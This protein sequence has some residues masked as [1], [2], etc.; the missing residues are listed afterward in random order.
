MSKKFLEIHL[1]QWFP[2]SCINRDDSG[3]PKSMPLGGE[4]RARWSSQSQ[5]Y[6]LRKA[7]ANSLETETLCMKTRRLPI[8]ALEVLKN[9]DRDGSEAASRIV[10]AMMTLGLSLN[11]SLASKSGESEEIKSDEPEEDVPDFG[12]YF[13]GRTQ[14]ILPV[15]QNADVLLADAVEKH[16][17]VLG[18]EVDLS[19]KPKDKAKASASLKKAAFDDLKKVLDVQRLVDVALFG[20]FLAEVPDGNVDGTC[21]VSH[22]F[23]TH[24]DDYVS[25]FWSAVDDDQSNQGHGGSAN[26]GIQGLTGGC[27]YRYG[28]IDLDAFGSDLLSEDPALVREGAA[29]F[30]REFT[31]LRPRAMVHGTAPYIDPALVVVTVSDTPRMLG[32]AFV[33]PVEEDYLAESA[34]RFARTWRA[35]SE[36]FGGKVSAFALVAHPDVQEVDLPMQQVGT[37]DALISSALEVAFDE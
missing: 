31:R 24:P 11:P 27:F 21:S 23:T 2:L 8:M 17:D 33:R 4:R 7:F 6:A 28:V 5:K 22:A 1:L 3:L 19:K 10:A 14:V 30:I 26:M 9:R 15:T 36:G 32:D 18:G 16:W 29:A 35:S 34:E 20:R 37:L 25:E 12:K 13:T